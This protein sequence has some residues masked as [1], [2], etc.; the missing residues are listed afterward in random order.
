MEKEEQKAKAKKVGREKAER[1]LE[2][3]TEKFYRALQIFGT[4]FSVIERLMPGR[5][6]KQIK[7]KFNKEEKANP[8]RIDMVLKQTGSY[9]LEDFEKCYGK[10]DGTTNNDNEF[11]E[12]KM[13][14]VARS[15]ENE[16]KQIISDANKE[17][18][19]N[20]PLITPVSYTHLTL[21]TIYSV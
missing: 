21:P 7:S 18:E 4:D 11:V 13:G 12:E 14:K 3:E 6:R 16:D 15:S 17:I 9:T 10:I 2:E 8:E 20:C 19:Y 1:W 5:S